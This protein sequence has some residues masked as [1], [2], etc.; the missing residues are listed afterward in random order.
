MKREMNALRATVGAFGAVAG[1]A[2][3][4]HGVGE[5]LQGNVAPEGM[6]ILSWP[7][8]ELFEIL[9]GEPAMTIVPNLV[10]SGILAILS[11][12]AFLLWTTTHVHRKHGG[13]VT[14][15]LSIV[16]LL[17]GAGFGPPMLGIILG[18]AAFGINGPLARWGAHL[19][20][21]SRRFLARVWPWSLTAGVIAWLLV[22]PGTVLLDLFFGV[23]NPN[24]VVPALTLSALGLLLLT[25]FT[26]FVYD[27]QRQIGLLST[28][29][30][31]EDAGRA[32]KGDRGTT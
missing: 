30:R 13:H 17:V 26:G 21:G 8:S 24:L 20:G 10:V 14:I 9:A 22:L 7:D 29:W 4:E 31:A 32:A 18:V 27:A 1:L 2:G 3:V 5:V 23:N 28:P 16:M 25:I 19:S 12:L 11:S 15:L 6:T